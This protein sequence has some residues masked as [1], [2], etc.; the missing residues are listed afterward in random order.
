[1]KLDSSGAGVDEIALGLCASQ[2]GR[3]ETDKRSLYVATAPTRDIRLENTN[4][5]I[6]D[7][8]SDRHTHLGLCLQ[9]ADQ[10]K[11]RRHISGILSLY[12]VIF[13]MTTCTQQGRLIA[14]A[15]MEVG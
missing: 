3:M 15:T 9:G 7:I 2:R 10:S 4:M 1:M 13:E 5:T 8:P 12:V 14:S 6:N 11:E